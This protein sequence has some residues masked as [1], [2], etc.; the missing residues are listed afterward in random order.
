[1]NEIPITTELACLKRAKYLCEK[2]KCYSSELTIHHKIPQELAL[3]LNII[4]INNLD[5]LQ[6]LCKNCHARIHLKQ[7][8]F[9]L[10]ELNYLL[11]TVKLTKAV[12]DEYL[13]VVPKLRELIRKQEM[14]EIGEEI[15]AKAKDVC[16]K[17]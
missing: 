9:S 5:N 13:R 4:N 16:E 17:K 11:N 15:R 3:A 2:C 14:R 12:T 10:E 1:M 8:Y 7:G 6:V